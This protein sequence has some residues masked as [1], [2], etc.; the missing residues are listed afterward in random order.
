MDIADQKRILR[1]T[2]LAKRGAIDATQR[3]TAAATVAHSVMTLPEIGAAGTVMAF[4][5]FG[6]EISTDPLVEALLASGR[7]VLMPY[8]D[9][10][11]LRAARIDSVA[12]LAPGYRGIREPKPDPVDAVAGAILVPGVA[13]DAGG[14]RLGYGGGFY[15]AFL[16]AAAGVRI[17]VCFECQIVERVP[18]TAA[19]QPVS[20]VATEIRILRPA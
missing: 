15:D 1:R 2:T 10:D 6:T 18:V 3:A 8:V 11:R 5:S 7:T 12:D 17:G 13:F 4:A 19:D 14:G 20:L 16:A 9:G